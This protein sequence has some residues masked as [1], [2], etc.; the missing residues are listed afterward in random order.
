MIKQQRENGKHGKWRE[1]LITCL[2]VYHVSINSHWPFCVRRLDLY[3]VEL[4]YGNILKKLPPLFL[5]ITRLQRKLDP[6]VP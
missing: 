4:H 1:N 3:C 2:S 5:S 6:K